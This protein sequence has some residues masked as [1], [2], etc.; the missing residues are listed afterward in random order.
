[1]KQQEK[2]KQQYRREEISSL[3]SVYFRQGEQMV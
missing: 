1:M 2:L 3:N